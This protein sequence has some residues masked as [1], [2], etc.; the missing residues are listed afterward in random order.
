VYPATLLEVPGS[1]VQVPR[2]LSILPVVTEI[3]CLKKELQ[4]LKAL[5]QNEVVF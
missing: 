1:G 4:E 2:G 3:G 5:Q